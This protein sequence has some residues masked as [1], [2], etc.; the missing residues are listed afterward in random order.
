MNKL[1]IL[2]LSLAV[3]LN[4]VGQIR[5]GSM[6]VR[7]VDG[8]LADRTA[9]YFT[10]P[11]DVVISFYYVDKHG[12]GK[13]YRPLTVNELVQRW[14][15]TLF[16]LQKY[17]TKDYIVILDVDSQNTNKIESL[18]DVFVVHRNSLSNIP[19]ND[20]EKLGYVGSAPLI[21]LSVFL[22]FKQSKQLKEKPV[23][24][25]TH[26]EVKTDHEV[27]VG[28][29]IVLNVNKT[30]NINPEGFDFFLA[31]ASILTVSDFNALKKDPDSEI[32]RLDVEIE[33]QENKIAEFKK[34]SDQ[35]LLKPYTELKNSLTVLNSKIKKLKDILD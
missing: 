25:F 1:L 10:N 5:K 29:Q 23:S 20:I 22:T 19:E 12:K 6:G 21:K 32:Q 11:D 9:K 2:F 24:N 3:S 8:P 7:Y 15:P 27:R 28:P 30:L 17:N 31:N 4:L 35:L 18:W 13:K 16:E 14:L 26:L 33:N 34:V